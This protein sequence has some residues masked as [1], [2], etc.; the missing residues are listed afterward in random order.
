MSKIT[1]VAV[2]AAAV[3]MF[4]A[5]AGWPSTTSSTPPTPY[6]AM[7]RPECPMGTQ[8]ASKPQNVVIKLRYHK[9]P[10]KFW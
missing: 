6:D 7:A 10:K 3:A 2:G 1:R 8:L 9:Q 5:P 4:G